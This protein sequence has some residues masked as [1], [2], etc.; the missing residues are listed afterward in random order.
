MPSNDN[1]PVGDLA[2]QPVDLLVCFAVKE[3]AKFFLPYP[4]RPVPSERPSKERNKPEPQKA[5]SASKRPSRRPM[6]EGGI[7]Q[8]WM[9]GIGRAN[10]ARSIR[11]AISLVKPE[12]VITAGFAGGLNPELKLGTVL[13]DQDYDAGF[14]PELED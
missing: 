8:V 13:Y 3:E 7:C 2:K 4:M 5:K 9:T 14:A 11:Q 10:A 6:Q 1:G 12:R